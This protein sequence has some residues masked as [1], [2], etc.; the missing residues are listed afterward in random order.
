L[1]ETARADWLKVDRGD[2]NNPLKLQ[3]G[4]DGERRAAVEVDWL[5]SI[6]E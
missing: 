3:S 2:L 1:I 4:S 5:Y 6:K